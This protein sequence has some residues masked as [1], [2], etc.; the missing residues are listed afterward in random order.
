MVLLVLGLL[1]FLNVSQAT[2]DANSLFRA[3]EYGDEEDLDATLQDR[4]RGAALAAVAEYGALVAAGVG[5]ILV[6]IGPRLRPLGGA[7]DVASD[8]AEA[9]GRLA[10]T[11]R[12]DQ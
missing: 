7:S 3:Q 12:G 6:V 4:Q 2:N 5:A 8:Q 9:E 11:N 1:T 10:P